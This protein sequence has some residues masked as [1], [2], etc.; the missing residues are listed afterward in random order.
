M[1]TVNTVH[2]RTQLDIINESKNYVDDK[3]C[4]EP[5]L[6][7]LKQDVRMHVHS[8]TGD[9]YFNGSENDS[10]KIT[11]Q[12]LMTNFNQSGGKEMCVI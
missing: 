3:T 2:A 4:L 6:C 7:C 11:A 9:C 5:R 12:V 10:Y 1:S 8:G